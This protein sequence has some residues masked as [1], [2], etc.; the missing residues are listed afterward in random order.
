LTSVLKRRRQS[1]AALPFGFARRR[2]DRGRLARRPL[3][4]LFQCL[5]LVVVLGIMLG[6]AG[7]STNSSSSGSS[8]SGSNSTAPQL[9]ITPVSLSFGTVTLGS[10]K[11]MAAAITNSG[12]TSANITQATVTGSG[13]SLSG[14]TLPMQLSAGQSTT[15]TLTFNPQAAGSATGNLSIASNATDAALTLAMTGTAVAPGSLVANPTSLAFGNVSVGTTQELTATLTNTGGTSISISQAGVTGGAFGLSGLT[16]PATL[17]AGQSLT[18]SVSFSPTS[19]GAA[20]GNVSITS[21]ASS[22]PLTVALSGS[23]VTA[24]ALTASPASVSFGSVAVG[25]SLNQTVTFTNTGGS[26]LSISQA[27]ATGTGFS[28]S[29]IS[30]PATLAA[31]QTLNLTATFA[32]TASGAATGN[33]AVTS[34]ASST[35]LNVPLSGTGAAAGAITA[36]PAS[37]SFGTVVVG[38]SLNQSIM[39]TNTG[40]STVSITQVALTGGP[41]NI[42][43][44]SLPASLGAGQSLTFTAGFV[45]SSPGAASGNIA[46]T[47][48]NSATPLNIPLSGTGISP[49]SLIATPNSVNFGNVLQGNNQSQS[50]TLTNSGGS[51]LT[52]SQANVT[53]SGFSIAGLSLP[54]TL[55]AGQSLGFTASFAPQSLGAVS[56]N[57]AIVNGSSTLNIPLSGT[58]VAQGSLT[59][60]PASLDFGTV[61]TGSSQSLSV[62]ITNSGGTSVTVSQATI[63]GTGFSLGSLTL[64]FTLAAGQSKSVSVTFAP[65]AAGAATGNLSIVSNASNSTLNIALSGTGVT[66]GA[67]TASPSSLSFGNVQV[68]SSSPL[69]E[70]ITNSGGSSVTISQATISGTGFSFTGLTVPQTLTAGQSVS[71][72]VTFA[73]TTSGS[74]SG[75]LAITSNAPNPNLSIPLS[76]TGT[77]PAT[78]SV[79]PTSLSFGSVTVGLSSNLT[80]TL[81]ASGSSV[82]VTSGSSNS[83]EF[84]LSGISFPV[85]INAGQSTQFTVT[86]SP[87]SSGAASGTIT[88]V[89][90]ATNSPTTQSVSGTGTAPPQHSVDLTWNPSTSVV[91]GYNVYRGTK[92]G[93][94]YTKINS[95]LDGS[96]AYTDSTVQAGQ[97]YYF[98]TTAVDS[99]GAESVYSNQVTA[100]IPTP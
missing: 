100:V 18:M 60:S 70:K 2:L 91:V 89:S 99:T 61:Q 30:L 17:D 71:F 26:S 21:S 90:N 62:S 59:A 69:T 92:S 4:H 58:G 33:I 40:G 81:N 86:F 29:G 1:F 36:S 75:S 13:F 77:N 35:T 5:A 52:I 80:G 83:A 98:V 45:P 12:G 56:G 25:N 79:S 9:A 87:Q 48:S 31:G 57:I 84:V 53:G 39:L 22:T 24:G 27:A 16:L 38:N 32:P 63:S 10:S 94:P 66:P 3:A 6:C 19:T 73:P 93:G 44:L 15:I 49:G 54:I 97:T 20:S 42:S 28:V 47:S 50:L 88:F 78:L 7:V 68:G 96:T 41:F 43:G 82:T 8:G 55:T 85:T 65:S 74:A 34:S 14:M 67:L 64:P 11:Q 46:V 51:S 37:V 76:G 23:G 72:T 95:S